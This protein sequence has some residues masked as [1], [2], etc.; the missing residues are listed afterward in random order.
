MGSSERWGYDSRERGGK[1]DL[2]YIEVWAS[3]R[4]GV[5]RF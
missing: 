4:V 1:W 3:W 2:L 5:R